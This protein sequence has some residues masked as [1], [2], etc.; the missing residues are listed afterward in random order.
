MR[1]GDSLLLRAGSEGDG[2]TLA[3][4]ETGR[5]RSDAASRAGYERD[6]TGVYPAFGHCL[7]SAERYVL[8]AMDPIL[9]PEFDLLSY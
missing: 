7:L 3:C 1:H 4:Q 2:G 5:R 9:H 6:A 8:A